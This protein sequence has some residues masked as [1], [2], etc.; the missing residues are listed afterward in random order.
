MKKATEEKATIEKSTCILSIDDAFF[1]NKQMM[2]DLMTYKH[3]K[4]F[5]QEMTECR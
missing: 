4:S 3:E 5:S 2:L 1:G